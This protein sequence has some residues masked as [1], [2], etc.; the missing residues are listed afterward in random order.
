[1]MQEFTTKNMSDLLYDVLS[2]IKDNNKNNTEAVLQIPTTES[3]FPCRLINTPI[4]SVLKSENA[5]PIL[6]KFQITIEHWAS[7]QRNCME[8]ASN[9]D[10]VL[11]K[12]NMLRTNTQQIQYDE[13]TKKYR[14]ITTYEVRW[15]GLTNSFQFIR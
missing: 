14:L 1:M 12:R 5:V 3:V 8:M 10:K 15:N 9:T 13:I 2:E 4:D 11:Q 7:Q 6:K